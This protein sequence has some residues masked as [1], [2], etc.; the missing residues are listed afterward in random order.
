V[1][2]PAENV[3]PDEDQLMDALKR[4][5]P[6]FMLPL[7]VEWREALP[8]NPHGKYDRAKLR[9]EFQSAFAAERA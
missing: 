7:K 1:V 2:T 4:R 6:R 3:R 8:R 5:L 9:G